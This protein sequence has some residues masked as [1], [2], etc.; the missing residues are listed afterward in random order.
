ML[1]SQQL[2]YSVGKRQLVA[3]VSVQ[4]EPA[5]VTAIVGPNGAGKS[6]LMRMLAGGAAPSSGRVLLNQRCLADWDRLA[7]ARTRAVVTQFNH[8]AFPFTVR[9]IVELGRAPHRHHDTRSRRDCAVDAAMSRLGIAALAAREYPSLSGGE[10]QRVAIARALA[11]LDIENPEHG[12]RCLLLDE[13]TASLDLFHQIQLLGLLREF[14]SQGHSA[15]V[16]LHD[17]NAALRTT[18]HT[19]VMKDG[20]LFA[21]GPTSGTLE[22]ALISEVFGVRADSHEAGRGERY[23]TFNSGAGIRQH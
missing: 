7:L 2:S 23:L 16:V 3:A 17:L 1:E 5:A 18:D 19:V 8:I 22:P 6:T 21:A 12:P 11:Q 14:A 20:R 9:Q 15:V 13:P 10:Q 4:F